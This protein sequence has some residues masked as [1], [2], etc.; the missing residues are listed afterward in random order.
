MNLQ[1]NALIVAGLFAWFT[2]GCAS[3]RE[4]IES[5][6]I[7]W[8]DGWKEDEQTCNPVYLAEK[9]NIQKHLPDGWMCHI[10]TNTSTIGS[11]AGLDEP[12]F[13]M[14]FVNKSVT[15]PYKDW[16]GNF[17]PIHPNFYLFFY[18]R[19]G[20]VSYTHLTLPTNREV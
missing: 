9:T 12:L 3:Q 15:L 4:Y 19:A 18:D 8:G 13:A 6:E 5:S 10:F 11:F 17:V 20:A 14:T 16:P 7:S 2:S 1:N